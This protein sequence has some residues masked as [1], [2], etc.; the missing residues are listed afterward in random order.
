[1]DLTPAATKNPYRYIPI[2][3]QTCRLF[4]FV[5]TTDDVNFPTDTAVIKNPD[6]RIG[7]SP[8]SMFDMSPPTP[9]NE[10]FPAT[11]FPQNVCQ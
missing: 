5:G 3:L 6:L 4:T 8:T 9:T 2:E 10:A 7:T 1:M 11:A